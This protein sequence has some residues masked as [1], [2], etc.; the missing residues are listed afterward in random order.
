MHPDA[1]MRQRLRWALPTLVVLWVSRALT[2]LAFPAGVRFPDSPDYVSPTAGDF[3]LVSLLGMAPR[4]W[5]TPLLMALFPTDPLR[6][7]AQLTISGLAWTALLWVALGLVHSTRGRL[8]VAT[9][10]AVLG[11][12]AQ[13]LQWDVAFLGASLLLAG[14]VGLLAV[15]L[16]IAAHG[17]TW[18]RLGLLAALLVLVGAAKSTQVILVVAALLALVFTVGRSMTRAKQAACLV[19][20]VAI[21]AASAVV[22]INVDRHWNITY[23]G[24]AALWALGAQAPASEQFAQFLAERGAPA[25]ITQDAPYADMDAAAGRVTSGCPEA[26]P[27]LR[28]RIVGEMVS[29]YLTQPTSAARNLADGLGASFVSN[30][31]RYGNAVTLVP[32]SVS[33]VAFGAVQPDPKFL[34]AQDQA[35]A[36]AALDSIGGF[37][38]FTP[39]LGWVLVGLV[40]AVLLVRRGL[41]ARPVGII[42]LAMILGSTAIAAASVLSTPSEWF[43]LC[44]AYWT[45]AMAAA[46]VGLGVVISGPKGAPR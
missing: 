15:L 26:A 39:Q 18:W 1:P 35:A 42:I 31:I 34:D 22:G 13:T 40:S 24:T 11:G 25:C 7:L 43:R 33:Q 14:L 32:D 38:V 12:A 29:F 45:T 9:A 30:G 3:S 46:A 28:D 10:I 41:P 36:I 19:G 44:A 6:V 8:L 16:S 4:G 37:W 5:P 21:L 2:W 17:A 27:Y 20:G 23:S